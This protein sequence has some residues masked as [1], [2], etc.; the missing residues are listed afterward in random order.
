MIIHQPDHLFSRPGSGPLQAG[1]GDGRLRVRLLA[2]LSGPRQTAG[3]DGGLLLADQPG[4]PCGVV[5]VEGGAAPSACSSAA[6]RG[7]AEEDVPAASAQQA[8]GLQ[9][10]QAERQSGR[11]GTVSVYTPGVCFAAC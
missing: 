1:P 8:A 10:S 4:L 6:V 7:V 11:T 9:H 3:S 2:G 5:G